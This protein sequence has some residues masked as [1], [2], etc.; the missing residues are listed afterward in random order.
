MHTY[1]R[2]IFLILANSPFFFTILWLKIHQRFYQWKKLFYVYP[3]ESIFFSQL[4]QLGFAST[5]YIES[6]YKAIA[7]SCTHFSE[8]L[9]NYQQF[10]SFGVGDQTSIREL[11]SKK[12]K[13]KV[14]PI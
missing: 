9:F 5:D 3:H 14:S 2:I 8:L 12:R 11:K 4:K 10:S 1:V 13:E 6:G 7:N